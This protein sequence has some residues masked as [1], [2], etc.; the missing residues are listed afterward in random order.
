MGG[1]RREERREEGGGRED[2]AGALCMRVPLSGTRRKRHPAGDALYQRHREG[3]ALQAA[4]RA[5][6][7][8]ACGAYGWRPAPAAPGPG[9]LRAA[10]CRRRPAP[11]APM[12]RF[13]CTLYKVLHT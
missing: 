2:R 10:S 3:G 9:S 11:A 13:K 1:V 7:T 4:L 8:F 12:T 6:G 5:C